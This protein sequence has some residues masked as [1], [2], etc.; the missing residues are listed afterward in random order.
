M[1]KEKE[2][3]EEEEVSSIREDDKEETETPEEKEEVIEAKEV[4]KPRKKGKSRLILFII[5]LVLAVLL[6]GGG[7]YLW[8]KNKNKAKQT[9][10]MTAPPKEET[11]KTE[12]SKEESNVVY[13]SSQIGL[14]MRKTA[15]LTAE[16]ITVLKYGTKLTIEK[17]E[18]SFY[19][20]KDGSGN[21]GYFAKEFTSKTDP[22]SEWITYN[23]KNYAVKY[24][25]DWLK[26]TCE[27]S[28]STGFGPDEVS[29]Q[30]CN[31]EKFALITMTTMEGTKA[32]YIADTKSGLDTFTESNITVSGTAAM[33]LEGKTKGGE[34]GP[35]AGSTSISVVLES[36]SD[37]VVLSYIQSPSGTDYSD[38]FDLIVENFSLAG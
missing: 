15:S 31:S 22:L 11:E 16:I 2:E 6:S 18:G 24:P 19:L 26:K 28:A 34:V 4:A 25:K 5:L 13:V 37:I 32:E 23:G 30:L 17:E 10:E 7:I 33:R 29:L 36:G 35:Q 27:D 21:E 1:D 20:G 38:I 8:Q 3:N 12:E 14:N 9:T